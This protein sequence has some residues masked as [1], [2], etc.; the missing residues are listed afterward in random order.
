MTVALWCCAGASA[1]RAGVGGVRVGGAVVGGAVVCRIQP[2]DARGFVLL[3]VFVCLC[4][5]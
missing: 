4:V 2:A 3:C 5:C 1:V